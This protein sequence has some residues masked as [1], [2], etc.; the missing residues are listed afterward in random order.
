[1]ISKDKQYRTR[2]G[3]EV[4][5][6]ATDGTYP[7]VVHGAYLG[8]HGWAACLW[9]NSGSAKEGYL[10]SYDLVEIKPRPKM[11]TDDLVTRLRDG[12]ETCGT[13]ACITIDANSGCLCALAADRIE[14]LEAAL[15]RIAQHDLQAIAMDALRPGERAALE[16]KDD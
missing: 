5:I 6:Y 2:S 15:R 12:G 14:Q 3:Y 4:R 9:L 7:N 8:E 10:R 1:M 13:E 16:G 11:M